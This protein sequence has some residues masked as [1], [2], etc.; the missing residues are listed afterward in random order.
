MEI[1]LL[2]DL[3]L[4][5]GVSALSV[6]VLHKLKIPPLIGFIFA[7]VLIGPHGAGFISDTHEIEVLAEIGVILLLFS[8][9]IEFSLKKLIR[10]RN[11]VLFSGGTQVLLTIAVTAALWYPHMRNIKIVIFFGFITALS[12]TAIV[13]KSLSD[14]GDTSSPHGRKM[15]GVLIFQDLCVVPLM[16][17]V[18]M[19]AGEDIGIFDLLL[20][21]LKAAGIVMSVL[22]A[23]RWL[24]PGILH[25]VVR[26]RSRELFLI[27]IIFICLGTALVTSRFGLSL[28]L[29][30]FLA[31]LVLSESAYAY[32][33]TAE[34]V[35]FKDSFLGIFFVS[36][37][38]LMDTSFIINNLLLVTG[39]V[40]F[41]LIL[42]S[43]VAT[44]S[45]LITSSNTR[46]SIYAGIGLAQ[47]GEFSF[48]LAES[49][50]HYGLISENLFQ[51]FLSAA[52]LTMAMTPFLIKAAAPVSLWLNDRLPIRKER[53]L[54]HEEDSTLSLSGH[55]IIIGFGLNGK[56]LA[57][58]LKTA[59]IPYIALDLNSMTVRT[60]QGKGEAIIYG[61]ATR[62]EVL[63]K[64]GI[65][66]AR[67][68]VVAISD[69]SA[70]KQIVSIARN[71]NPSLHIVVRT[72]YLAEVDDLNTLGA[73]E[74]IPEE[75]ETSVEIFSRILNLY[76]TPRNVINNYINEIRQNE[77]HVLRTHD[78]PKKKASGIPNL[79]GVIETEHFLIR[80]HSVVNGKSVRQTDLRNKT[81]ATIIAI[82]HDGELIQN[83]KPDH[84]L[85]ENE[86]IV[87]VGRKDE[88]TKSIE[89]L[90]RTEEQ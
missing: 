90:N 71:N 45:I 13:M 33:A 12:S 48:I 54:H 73:D 36:I 7:G 17:A 35:P 2:Y 56:N 64:L 39:S 59:G 14:S 51:F 6:L 53:N 27:T 72:R 32:Q 61:D 46:A 67:S 20:T 31:G 74:V 89:F 42:K 25:Q 22:I 47:A 38:M 81:G 49:G 87:L 68:M 37:G 66:N 63:N 84:I 11:V 10:I 77:Y 19:L 5:F 23:A 52:V 3:V 62:H 43:L 86:T 79:L 76:N 50:K 85:Q 80:K 60:E 40:L 34:I 75:F 18:P 44:L 16:L 83:P 55:V 65:E 28:A 21:M 4:V 1:A 58:T 26:T 88:L 15:M 24:V 78:L 82:E 69:P 8:I 30:A 70:T 29:G 57:I 41:I 9:G